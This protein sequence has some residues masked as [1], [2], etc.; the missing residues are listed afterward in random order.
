MDLDGDGDADALSA[1]EAGGTV[2][3]YEDNG[4]QSFVERVITT[5]ADGAFSVHALDLDGDGDV[6]A[7]AS[8]E[9]NRFSAPLDARRGGVFKYTDV[10]H[11]DARRG[12][13]LLTFCFPRRW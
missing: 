4:S 2:S 7:S 5:T 11:L 6:D 9:S 10:D 1:S 3:W 12:D 8:A 13:P